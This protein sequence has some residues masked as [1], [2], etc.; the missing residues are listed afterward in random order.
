M[1]SVTR[2]VPYDLAAE[3]WVLGSILLERTA[4]VPVDSLLVPD[5]FYLET[6]QQ[7]YAAMR[8]LYHSTPRVPSDLGTV[9]AELT[10]R[11][12]L[13]PVGGV[14]YLL[15]LM[16]SVATAVHAEY[17]ATTV[18]ET[19][20]DRASI[21]VGG[22]I[23]GLGFDRSLPLEQRLERMER[24]LLAVTQRRQR[25][26][27]VRTL[28]SA[29]DSYMADLAARLD[30]ATPAPG[31][32]TGIPRLDDLTGGL[33]PGKLWV[34]VGESGGGKS[35]FGLG[36][37]LAA[38]QAGAR[39][40]FFSLEMQERE[41]AEKALAHD[42]LVD[43]TYMHA[44]TLSDAEYQRLQAAYT[45]RKAQRE[46]PLV[47][48][49]GFAY[50]D[51]AA[52]ARAWQVAGG[53]D[54]LAVDYLGLVRTAGRAGDKVNELDALVNDLKGLG[55]ELAI[56]AV[57]FSQISNAGHTADPEE[58]LHYL[59]GSGAIRHAADVILAVAPQGE[60]PTDPT[61]PWPVQL[62]VT[63]HRGGPTGT[64]EAYW[65]LAYSLMT[66]TLVESYV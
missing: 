12:Q 18:L 28:Q 52:Q 55:M 5:D 50:R 32:T 48:G 34:V 25:G 49:G 3:R 16:N 61:Q 1:D 11:G 33:Q 36:L 43:S 51:I 4:I 59:R 2:A 53:L 64:V 46:A 57:T 19:S 17:Y 65:Y 54:G 13:A 22:Q 29:M 66:D 9:Q 6:H 27:P 31:W 8:D 35:T 40:G 24:L 37:V 30:G 41:L 60:R 38:M 42:A 47:T 10:R 21:T 15:D 26:A 39:F 44:G 45:W 7:I 62:T 58:W 14:A 20:I 63:K 23:A 56:P